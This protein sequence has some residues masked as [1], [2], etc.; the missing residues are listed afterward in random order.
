MH[1][2]EISG[3]PTSVYFLRVKDDRVHCVVPLELFMKFFIIFFFLKYFQKIDY[4][5]DV[6]IHCIYVFS[7][8]AGLS[9]PININLIYIIVKNFFHKAQ[10]MR[11]EK[12]VQISQHSMSN[13]KRIFFYTYCSF[14]NSS[15]VFFFF[16]F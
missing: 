8:W 13:E 11:V 15:M 3:L 9:K 2:R 10:M 5:F 14:I 16:F 4:L 7:F 1:H 12:I 6:C